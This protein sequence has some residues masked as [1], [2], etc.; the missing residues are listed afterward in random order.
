MAPS[1][2]LGALGGFT[3][4]VCY[5]RSFLFPNV[6]FLLWGD[7]LG[8]AT[9]G[10]RILRGEL[11]YR[12]FFDFVT[13]GTEL[14]YAILFHWIGV[15]LWLPN[16][17]MCIMATMTTLWVTWCARRLV[18][19][20]FVLLP[21][22]LV[23]GFV[24]AG[25]FDAT[26]H[27]FSTLF[28]MAAVAVLFDGVSSRRV[29]TAGALCGMAA[30]F[31][32]SKGAAVVLAL[33][34]YLWW[35]SR[36]EPAQRVLSR[37]RGLQLCVAAIVTFAIVNFPFVAAAGLH[38]W[39]ADLIG[40]PL[41]YF[42]S[43]S[44]NNWH[45][46]ALQFTE[47][48]GLLKW[49]CLPFLYLVVPVSY[50]WIFL[51]VWKRREGKREQ[52]WDQLLLLALVGGAMLALVAPSLSM[53]RISC[54]SPPA[55]ILVVWLLSRKERSWQIAARGLAAISVVVALAQVAAA[56]LHHADQLDLPAGHVAIRDLRNAE[57]YR[58]MASRTHPGQWYFG[59]PPYTLP[60]ALKNPT[61]IEAPGPGDYSRPGQIAAVVEGL[62]RTQTEILLLRP[63]MYI[64]H[65]LGYKA[66]HLQP[67]HDYLFGHYRR[68]KVFSTG[69]EVW[70]RIHPP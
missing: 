28:V 47:N 39:T 58:W 64:P 44:A 43:V 59:M 42:G 34:A 60:L 7:A 12:D 69:D 50:A 4:L 16:L 9:K 21:G 38:R 29:V 36:Q 61:P 56:Q 6:P 30:S 17:L 57:V 24:L 5:L 32:Q 62:E 65:L 27:W 25:S 67:F 20:D 33:L 52:H 70:E 13:P 35:K 54:V 48:Q 8:Y 40:F 15:A 1:W 49:V 63:P 14:V 10:A 23:T 68:T 3:F 46:M 66:D 22:L 19:G 11:P 55:M 37:R 41:R 53:R 18:H 45:V 31:T 26:H 2:F 51:Q